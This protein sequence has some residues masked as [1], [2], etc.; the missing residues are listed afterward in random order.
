GG[1]RLDGVGATDR[2]HACFGEAEVLHLA[3]P[4]QFLHGSR[5]VFDGHVRVNPMLI[6]QVDTLDLEPLERALGGLL[7]VVWATVQARRTLHP[8]GIQIRTEVK[9]EFGADDYLLAE[10]SESLAHELFV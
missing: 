4:N 2:L 5:H 7:D 9:P 8:A 3:L 6:E 10:R 1:E